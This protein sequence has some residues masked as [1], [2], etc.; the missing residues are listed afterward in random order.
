VESQ[1]QIQNYGRH[2]KRVYKD[3]EPFA[4]TD[5]FAGLGGEQREHGGG[6][7]EITSQSA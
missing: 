7:D 4:Q 2:Q 5:G 1:T 6:F 3:W